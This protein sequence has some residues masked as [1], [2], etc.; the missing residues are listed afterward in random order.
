M[1]V[2]RHKGARSEVTLYELQVRLTELWPNYELQV[3]WKFVRTGTAYYAKWRPEVGRVGLLS[4]WVIECEGI[5][6]AT[7][8]ERLVRK[9]V[10]W[11]GEFD[12]G[13]R[14]RHG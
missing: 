11:K 9:T 1:P 8:F 7:V 2:S 10:Q 6:Q 13:A 14:E 4:D 3:G 5:H 12:A